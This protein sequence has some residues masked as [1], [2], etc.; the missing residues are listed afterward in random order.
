MNCDVCPVASERL[1]SCVLHMYAVLIC[2]GFYISFLMLVEEI[3]HLGLLVIFLDLL[4]RIRS[5]FYKR[6]LNCLF[7][8]SLR[9]L[10]IRLGPSED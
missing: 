10:A 1:W 7:F 9:E 3:F 5:Y 6:L 2:F 4:S 8:D